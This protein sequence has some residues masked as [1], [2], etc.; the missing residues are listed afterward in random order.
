[1]KNIF[2]ANSYLNFLLKVEATLAEAQAEI[3]IIPKEAAAEIK[4]GLPLVKRQR[5]EEIES[6]INHDVMAVVKGLEEKVGDARRRRGERVQ[7]PRDQPVGSE[8]VDPGD[9]PAASAAVARRKRRKR[10]GRRKR[11]RRRSGSVHGGRV[12]NV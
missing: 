11:R 8:D 7:R 5:V 12:G 9:E 4:K 3:G 10:R 6:E 2:R 1:M